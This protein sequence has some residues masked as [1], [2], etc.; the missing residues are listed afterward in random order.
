M[1]RSLGLCG[2]VVVLV[3]C[4]DKKQPTEPEERDPDQPNVAGS[5]AVAALPPWFMPY[6]NALPI[7][8]KPVWNVCRNN[9]TMHPAGTPLVVGVNCRLIEID[10]YPRRY[11]VY[12]PN[13]PSVVQGD[14]V[15][16][17]VMY[18]GSSQ[19]GEHFYKESAW[20]EQADSAGFIV[21]YPSGLRYQL[22]AGNFSSKWNSY[23][24][25]AEVTAL[26]PPGYPGGAPWPADDS[27]FTHRLLDDL[28]ANAV[29]DTTRIHA[30][31]FSNGGSFVARLSIELFDRFASVASI[32]SIFGQEYT[33]LGYVPAFFATGTL[34]RNGLDHINT[35]LTSQ[36]LPTITEIPIDPAVLFSYAPVDTNRIATANTYDLDPDVYTTL[37]GANETLMQ[38]QTPQ[39]GNLSGNETWWGLIRG[40]Q[41][42]YP[43]GP[44]RRYPQ[45]NPLGYDAPR[46]FWQFFRTHPK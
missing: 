33:P 30:S 21:A 37:L 32:T 34:D 23:D 40:V 45:N 15:P 11:V 6:V 31:G 36:G 7:E 2:V 44:G 14:S 20:R 13:H 19:S 4:N 43:R 29:V 1:R 12:V 18:H 5:V 39:A 41:H 16:L 9:G 28:L 22:V 38:W 3:A 35:W 24:L 25:A 10:G 26:T 8:A 27:T 46:T 17:V 42:E